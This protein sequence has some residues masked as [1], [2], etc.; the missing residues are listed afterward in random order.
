MQYLLDAA[1]YG[2][3]LS[4]GMSIPLANV[5]SR[6][7]AASG[8]F[9]ANRYLTFSKRSDTLASFRASLMR[10]VILWILMTV[11]STGLMILLSRVWGSELDVLVVGKLIV[12]AV[13]AVIS[14]LISKFW[15]YRD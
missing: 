2:I 10:F 14:F 5:L 15:V 8:G 12:E 1:L 7:A 6:G 9:L 4:V 3:L 13:L 11:I